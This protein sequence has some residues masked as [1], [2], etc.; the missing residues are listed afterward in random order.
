MTTI[1]ALDQ[2]D[3]FF[4]KISEIYHTML[5]PPVKLQ[6]LHFSVEEPRNEATNCTLTLLV[7]TAGRVYSYGIVWKAHGH[8]VGKVLHSVAY[9]QLHWKILIA[10]VKLRWAVLCF[11]GTDFWGFCNHWTRLLNSNFNALKTFLPNCSRPS[12]SGIWKS[13]K[14]KWNGNWKWKWK[15]KTEIEMQ[16]LSSCSHSNVVGFGS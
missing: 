9:A 4:D 15:R 12:S 5:S 2:S 3:E 14:R 1:S 6:C 13:R 11:V 10:L 16:P 7:S 8:P